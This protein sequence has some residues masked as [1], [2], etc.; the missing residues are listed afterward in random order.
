MSTIPLG[1]SSV[2]KFALIF[3]LYLSQGVATTFLLLGVPS[4]LRKYG[5]PLDLLW[6]AY[7]PPVVYSVKFLWA[8]SQTGTG[9]RH[10]ADGAA[11]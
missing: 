8:R 1:R 6:V 9:F 2:A 11:G 10:W 5:M 7:L 3:S 4:V